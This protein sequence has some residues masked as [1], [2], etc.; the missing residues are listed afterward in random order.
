MQAEDKTKPSQVR[1]EEDNRIGNLRK[2]KQKDEEDR[3]QKHEE[4]LMMLGGA[5]LLLVLV[6]FL[7]RSQRADQSSPNTPNMHSQ[8]DNYRDDEAEGFR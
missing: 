8:L 1:T 5:F 7:V 6:F 3:Y 2:E 4:Q